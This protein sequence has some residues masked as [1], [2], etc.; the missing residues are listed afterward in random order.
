MRSAKLRGISNMREIY[1]IENYKKLAMAI[2]QQAAEDYIDAKKKLPKLEKRLEARRKRGH[3]KD[4]TSK[5]LEA[6]ILQYKRDINEAES[7]FLSDRFDIYMPDVD[8]ELF[9]QELKKK[10]A[11]EMG[12]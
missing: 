9:L 5:L 6:K 7:F 4:S 1:P 2:V 8:G 3:G 12:V 10:A 11:R